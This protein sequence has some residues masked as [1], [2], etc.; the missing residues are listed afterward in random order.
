MSH[1][2]QKDFCL[3]VKSAFPKLFDNV[4]V[5]DIGSLDI[6]G[7]NRDYFS[8]SD[9]IGIDLGKGKN[10]DLVCK[11]HDF[12]IPEKKFDVVISTECFEHDMYLSKTIGRVIEILRSGGLFIF[13]CATEG[14]KEHGTINS[15]RYDS[16]FTFDMK[17]GWEK[18]YKNV[19][20]EMIRQIIHVDK[21]FSRYKFSVVQ[22][23]GDLQFWGIKA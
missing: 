2:E 21:V 12:P 13:T 14:R 20:E 19:T 5:L 23:R 8:N 1:K 22:K 16:P 7:N 17:N 9:Y 4:K 18:Y 3:K 10:V 11:A 15:S 6:N